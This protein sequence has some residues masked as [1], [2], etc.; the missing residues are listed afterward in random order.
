[1]VKLKSEQSKLYWQIQKAKKKDVV[2]QIL[3]CDDKE[4]IE[5][6]IKKVALFYGLNSSDL[7][8]PKRHA[9]ILIPRYICVRVLNRLTDFGE[10]IM[11]FFNRDQTTWY[12]VQENIEQLTRKPKYKNDIENLVS[13]CSRIEFINS[14]YSGD[15]RYNWEVF[16]ESQNEM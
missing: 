9:A 2:K 11:Y 16:K 5:F 15:M 10:H 13:L 12:N 14:K 8:S 4:Y 3:E 6:I 7:T 1:M